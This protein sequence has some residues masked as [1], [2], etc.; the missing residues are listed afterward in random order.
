MKKLF[1]AGLCLFPML[2]FA[3][4]PKIERKDEDGNYKVSLIYDENSSSLN[5]YFSITP[6]LKL[7]S[8][9]RNNERRI[10]FKCYNKFYVFVDG[11]PIKL[12]ELEFSSRGSRIYIEDSSDSESLINKIK[13]KP[14]MYSESF[15][16]LLDK[17]ALFKIKEA[18]NITVKI[19]DTEEVLS[20]EEIEAIKGIINDYEVKK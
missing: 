5:K 8:V 10:F 4:N 16:F 7:F 3:A 17:E 19:C 11:T 12:K 2:I 9:F 1:L 18:S 20:N 6:E 15:D 13:S 14:K